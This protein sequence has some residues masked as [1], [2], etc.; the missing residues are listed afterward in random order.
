MYRYA[1]GV[2]EIQSQT[3]MHG[4]EFFHIYSCT[5]IAAVVAGLQ[6]IERGLCKLDDPLY[7]YIPEFAE[8]HVQSPAGEITPVKRPVYIRDLFTM[9]AG[10][11]YELD[12]P[13]I[14]RAREITKGRMDTVETIRCMASDPLQF[15]PGEVWNYSLC[16]DILG[17]LIS[18]ISGKKLREYVKENIFD[19]LDMCHSF[20][21]HTP[22][23]ERHMA[24]QY[25]FVPADS[26][27]NIYEGS[28][29]NVGKKNSLVLGEEYDSGGAGIISTL[30]DYTKLLSALSNYGM[31]ET[32]ERI[33]SRSSVE[34]LRTPQLTA[35]QM[36][37]YD[38][39]ILKGHGY[40]LGVQTHIDPKESGLA[41]NIG[42]FGWPG[43]AGAM[44][45]VDPQIGLA[46]FYLQ[47][48]MSVRNE[49]CI[50]G[51]ISKIYQCLR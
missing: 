37:T 48:T 38:W 9:T 49:E 2:S 25:R 26:D 28:F 13:G 43:A 42:A 40:G 31:G 29:E 50:M 5:K 46:A 12:T 51:L 19:P 34:H 23:T 17:G 18:L 44:A 47:H 15:Q 30:S 14:Q 41:W 27:Q 11:S 16:H 36:K 32:G 8:L 4:D 39:R 21:H 10:F 24:L 3:A 33:L 22:E 45:I 1:A 35:A 6:L 20:F 7:A